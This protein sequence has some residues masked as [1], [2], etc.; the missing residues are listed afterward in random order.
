MKAPNLQNKIIECKQNLVSLYLVDPMDQTV[1][2]FWLNFVDVFIYLLDSFLHCCGHVGQISTKDFFVRFRQMAE[3]SG[4]D[5]YYSRIE[6]V[7]A[8]L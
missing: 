3:I 5:F 1:G 8:V 2:L 6:M 4:N 7:V